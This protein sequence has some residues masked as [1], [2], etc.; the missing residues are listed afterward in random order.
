MPKQKKKQKKKW[1]D[2]SRG[3]QA[4]TVLGSIVQIGLLGAALWDIYHRPASQLRGTRAAWTAASFINFAGPI[5][6]FLFGRKPQ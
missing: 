3:R 1:S 4:A 5:A 2:L 6:Y